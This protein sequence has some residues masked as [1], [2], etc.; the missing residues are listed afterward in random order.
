MY[1]HHYIYALPLLLKGNGQ[2]LDDQSSI[3]IVATE[4]F[5]GG[6]IIVILRPLAVLRETLATVMSR[7]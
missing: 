5:L 3:H 2:L 1:Q 6:P 4:L 7:C